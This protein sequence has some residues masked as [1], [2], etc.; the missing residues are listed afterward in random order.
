MKVSL[1]IPI[2]KCR[3]WS[4]EDPFLYNLSVSTAG[5][6]A[7]TR[8]GMRTF[9]CDPRAKR[10]VLNDKMYFMR[11]SNVCIYRFFEDAAR[12][13]LPWRP[14]W[15]RRLHQ[16][17]RRMNWNSLRYCIGFP[18]EFWYDIADEE[19]FLIQDEFPIWTGD[20]APEKPLAAKI[21]PQYTEWMRER[22]NHPCVVIW[23]GQNESFTNETGKAICAVRGLDKSQ[24]PWRTAGASRKAWPTAANRTPIVLSKAGG[25]RSSS[26]SAT[27]KGRPASR[28]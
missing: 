13:D 10:V 22:W 12:G 9:R 24:R 2:A 28:T 25:A 19:G 18:P 8:F 5:D 4:P 6:A 27:W 17:F 14:D 16:Q 26:T 3:L 15:V 1:R 7:S 23:D 11:G 21:I 20:G